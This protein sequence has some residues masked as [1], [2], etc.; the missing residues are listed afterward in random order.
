MSSAGIHPFRRTPME[1]LR[2]LMIDL[3]NPERIIRRA[4]GKIYDR[5]K[6]FGQEGNMDGAHLVMKPDGVNL[7]TSRDQAM[8][9]EHVANRTRTSC[10]SARSTSPSSIPVARPLRPCVARSSDSLTSV[11]SM[12][13]PFGWAPRSSGR[14]EQA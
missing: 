14:L 6:A 4:T 5:I 2:T 7:L 13:A 11:S 3:E 8:I 12:T 1:P 10:S 9:E